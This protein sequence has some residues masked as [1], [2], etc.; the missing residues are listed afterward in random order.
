MR[1][2]FCIILLDDGTKILRI[3][4][5]NV[6]LLYIDLKGLLFQASCRNFAS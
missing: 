2:N 1:S 4:L 6:D 3:D 5:K